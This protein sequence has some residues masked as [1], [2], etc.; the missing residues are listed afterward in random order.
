[1]LTESFGAPP[2]EKF[3]ICTMRHER[4]VFLELDQYP[5]QAMTR[6]RRANAL[7]PGIAMATFLHPD[8]DSIQS[9]WITLPTR[10]DGPVYKGRRAGTIQAPDG[11]LVEIVEAA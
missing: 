3:T 2:D 4:D 5:S 7:P 6:P 8:F 10:R 1:M 9:G 11:T